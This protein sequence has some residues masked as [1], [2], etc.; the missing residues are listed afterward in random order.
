MLHKYHRIAVI[1]L[2][3]LSILFGIIFIAAYLALRKNNAFFDT[4]LPANVENIAVMALSLAALVR[5]FLAIL[6]IEHR[7]DL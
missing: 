6:R 4:G 3:V 7:K 2:I 5:V 1:S